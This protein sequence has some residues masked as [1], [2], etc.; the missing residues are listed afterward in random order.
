MEN[1]VLEMTP[2]L[3]DDLRQTYQSALNKG[4]EQFEWNGYQFVTAYAGHMLDYLDIQFGG[5]PQ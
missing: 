5:T 4:D 1:R 3:R 2:T